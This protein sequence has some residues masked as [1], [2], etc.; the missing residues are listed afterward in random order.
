MMGEVAWPFRSKDVELTAEVNRYKLNICKGAQV[1]E[2]E[3]PIPKLTR[4]RGR[5]RAEDASDILEELF[6]EDGHAYM[7]R[8]RH[9]SGTN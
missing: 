3:M 2:L 6:R 5:W 1:F 8:R 4:H 7:G 9:G